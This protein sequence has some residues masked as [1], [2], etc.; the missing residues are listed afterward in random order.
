MR[1][2]EVAEGEYR[3]TVAKPQGG[4]LAFTT[5]SVRS[6]PAKLSLRLR[7]AVAD[8]EGAPVRS[9]RATVHVRAFQEACAEGDETGTTTEGTTT[10]EDGTTTTDESAV[11]SVRDGAER[12]DGRRGRGRGPG[13]A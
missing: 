12:E 9:L 2:V 1:V 7:A 8:A 10:V 3:V 6:Q 5:D 4:D 13:R 11:R